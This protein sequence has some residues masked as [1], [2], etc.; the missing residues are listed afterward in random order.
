M[1]PLA[2]LNEIKE[3][4]HLV[5]T[6]SSA[7]SHQYC[8]CQISFYENRNAI[9]KSVTILHIFYNGDNYFPVM[10]FSVK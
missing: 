2:I 5:V 6:F 4:V 3:A 8:Y 10:L 1:T 9:F 7:I